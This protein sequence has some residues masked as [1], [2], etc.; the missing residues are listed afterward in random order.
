MRIYFIQ[1]TELPLMFSYLGYVRI[2]SFSTHKAK[3]SE[4]N[5]PL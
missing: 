3:H 1:P 4:L 5:E 2:G